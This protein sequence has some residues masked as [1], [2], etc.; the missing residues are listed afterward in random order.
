[1]YNHPWSGPCARTT[2]GGGFDPRLAAVAALAATGIWPPSLPYAIPSGESRL[3]S[4]HEGLS[5]QCSTHFPTS[6]YI[7]S[8]CIPLQIMLIPLVGVHLHIRHTVF[9]MPIVLV[10][11]FIFTNLGSNSFLGKFL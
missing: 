3:Q 1:M 4:V 11:K 8:E 6:F 7:H 9:P 2:G 10:S 5:F